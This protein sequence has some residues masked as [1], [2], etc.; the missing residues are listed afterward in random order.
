MIGLFEKIPTIESIKDFYSIDNL[1]S[2]TD[3]PYSWSNTVCTLDGVINLNEDLTSIGGGIAL[4]HVPQLGYLSEADFRILNAG[5]AFSD[6]VLIT[7]KILRDEIDAI[8]K[9]E[10]EDLTNLR[11]QIGKKTLQPLRLVLSSSG[12]IFNIRQDS[13]SIDSKFFENVTSKI[14]I[15]TTKK[16]SD[17]LSTLRLDY[18]FNFEWNSNVEIVI[19]DDDQLDN[20]KESIDL[21]KML[22]LLKIRFKIDYLD[23]SSG[24]TVIQQFRDLNVVDELRMT[25][26]PQIV[27]IKN[28]LGVDRPTIFPSSC[29]SYNCNNSPLLTW[30]GIRLLGE[31]M[32]FLRGIYQY[33]P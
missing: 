2:Y 21:R 29:K 7:G 18:K 23:V 22:K 10:F 15:L 5:W 25:I 14:I 8:C 24:G 16:G 1:N 20:G 9:I 17:Y 27:G 13:T 31:R 33:R 12:H 3:R 26:S 19:F 6:A 11:L 30:K 4:K 32:I 28:S